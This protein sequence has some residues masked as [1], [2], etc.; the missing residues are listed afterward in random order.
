MRITGID[1]ERFGAWENFSQSLYPSGLTVF[2]GP[3]EAGKT[4]LLRFIRG[5]LYGFPTEDSRHDRRSQRDAAPRPPRRFHKPAAQS[6]RLF[7]TH[8]GRQYEICRTSRGDDAGLVTIAGAEPGDSATDLLREFV[9]GADERLFESVFAV[10]LPELQEF[11]TLTEDEV[12]RHLYGMTLGPQGQ[13]LMELPRRIEQELDQLWPREGSRGTIPELTDRQRELTQQVQGLRPQRDRYRSLIRQRRD[14]EQKIQHLRKRQTE[15][16]AQLRGHQFLEKV[17]PAWQRARELRRE[18]AAIPDLRNFPADGLN[19]L[20]RLEADRDAAVRTRDDLLRDIREIG[21]Q[22]KNCVGK[23]DIRRFAGTIRALGEERDQWSDLRHRMLELERLAAEHDRELAAQVAA[24]GPRWTLARLEAMDDTPEAHARFVTAARDFQQ[25]RLATLRRQRRYRRW[26]A[27]CRDRELTLQAEL[28]QLGVDYGSLQQPIAS[29]RQRLA[30]LTELGKLQLQAAEL[31]QQSRAVG[32][33]L[34]RLRDRLGLPDWVW[35]MLA[36]F[37]LAGIGLFCAGLSAGLS[38][39]WLVGA[40]YVALALMAGGTTWALKLEF[41][42]EIQ[43]QVAELRAARADI[44]SRRFQIEGRIRELVEQHGLRTAAADQSESLDATD[45]TLIAQAAE[46]LAQLEVAQRDYQRIQAARKR[47]S[48]IR[49]RWQGYQRELA[50]SRKAWCETLKALGFDEVVNVDAAFAQWQ[51]VAA[52]RELRRRGDDARREL[53]GLREDWER[54][55]QKVADLGRRMRAQGLDEQQPFETLAH[56]ERELHDW[57]VGR[58]EFRRLSKERKL[59]RTEADDFQRRIDQLQQQIAA[60][61]QQAQATDRADLERKLKLHQRRQQVEL[62]LQQ[63]QRD[64][65]GIT[66]SEPNLALV[67]D[68]LVRYRPQEHAETLRRFHRDIAEIDSQLQELFEQ[69]GTIKQELKSLSADRSGCRL[70]FE[71]AQTQERLHD[72]WEGWAALALSAEAVDLVGALFE[73][74]HQPEMLSAALPFVE[75]LTCGKYKRLW[76]QLG[77]RKL[78]VDDELARSQPAEQLS[79]GTREQLFLAIRLAMVKAF[80]RQ[81]IELPM[82]LD[83][84]TVNFDNERSEAA[85]DTLLEFVAD[86]QQVLVFTSHLHFA[87]MFQRRGIEPIWLPARNRRGEP[88][89]G[90]LA[91]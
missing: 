24:I 62:L 57:I 66:Q 45:G 37:V 73:Q 48:L 21:V 30:Q 25:V 91:G 1:I 80:A 43:Q 36:L 54:F 71:L 7:I 29:S 74:S 35:A 83:D 31:A 76:T 10:G 19:R 4:T 27:A 11:A 77:C 88:L 65:E 72:A 55:R 51:Q 22:M 32:E 82:V 68:D 58:Q 17:Y 89:E 64:L 39:S 53:R 78:F 75:R 33:Q 26:S 79:G 84:V 46:R 69:L 67:E 85:V 61:L 6:G 8:R 42:R 70:R 20:D 38:T 50:A 41:E 40:I 16:Q 15:L 2:Y 47:L 86:G 52:A 87:Q 49:G 59:R 56:W 23:D 12:A 5:V 3:N 13:L 63:A 90:R 60:L 9:H 44:D 14:A 28:R 18:L 81:G 34:Q